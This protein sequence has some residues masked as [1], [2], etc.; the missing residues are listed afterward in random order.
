MNFNR[1]AGNSLQH[2]LD[3]VRTLLAIP[4]S[5]QLHQAASSKHVHSSTHR[6]T[7]PYPYPCPCP[8]H[9][10][11]TAR[12]CIHTSTYR[13][14]RVDDAGKNT[15]T[16]GVDESSDSVFQ[17]KGSTT[18]EAVR[19][20]G[21]MFGNSRM[22]IDDAMDSIG[23]TYY[24]DDAKVAIDS[25]SDVFRQWEH[26]QALAAKDSKETLQR[27]KESWSL[28]LEQLKGELDRMKHHEGNLE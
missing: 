22:D 21:E 23:T 2:Q 11:A 3:R 20:L 27:I 13:C 28:K 12:Q 1:S 5:T 10:F 16:Q 7:Y 25:V 9:F 8:H 4:R 26:V 15:A 18:D 6:S 24:S 14:R 17:G 19:E